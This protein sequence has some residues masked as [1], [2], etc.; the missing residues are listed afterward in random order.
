[1]VHTAKHPAATARST[2]AGLTADR[3]LDRFAHLVAE[4]VGMLADASERDRFVALTTRALNEARMVLSTDPASSSQTLPVAK[5]KVS[6]VISQELIH[7]SQASLYRAAENGRFYCTTPSG[8]SSGR[9]FPAWQFIA[10]VPELIGT[11]LAKLAGLPGSE[12]HAFWITADDDLNELSPAEMLAGKPFESREE[13][14]QS[15]HA[16]LCLPTGVRLEKVMAVAT[17]RAKGMAAVIG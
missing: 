4:R 3:A 9:E 13:L 17:F 14:H 11:V 6:E 5:L 12:I 15:Q 10:P 1:M 2:Q 16:L 7:L 8:R